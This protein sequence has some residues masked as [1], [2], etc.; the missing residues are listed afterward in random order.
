MG[1]LSEAVTTQS[2]WI[3]TANSRNY[4]YL[5]QDIVQRNVHVSSFNI[6]L[7]SELLFFFLLL[8]LICLSYLPRCNVIYQR[9]IMIVN[10]ENW[11]FHTRFQHQNNPFTVYMKHYLYFSEYH[12]I[13]ICTCMCAGMQ[14]HVP[15]LSTMLRA[16]QIFCCKLSTNQYQNQQVSF[17]PIN[18]RNKIIIE[19]GV[20]YV[21]LRLFRSYTNLTKILYTVR[22]P[23]LYMTMGHV[24]HPNTSIVCLCKILL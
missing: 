22:A 6:F 24:A 19:Y 12:V 10:T 4:F 5:E 8:T 11:L 21:S 16:W 20:I 14:Q 17:C 9:D 7:K 2:V 13:Y 1:N 18:M 3:K 23:Y 15:P